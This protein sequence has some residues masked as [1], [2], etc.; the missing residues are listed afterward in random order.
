MLTPKSAA[1]RLGVS[2]SLIYQLCSQGLL[3]HF[4]FGG[5]GRRGSLRINEADLHAYVE[6]CR[7][8]ASASAPLLSL[9]HINLG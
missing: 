7:R 4:R 9:Q 1:E 3:P 2:L 8:E 6:Q 5:K